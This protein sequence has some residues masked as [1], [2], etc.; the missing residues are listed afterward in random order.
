MSTQT[1]AALRAAVRRLPLAALLFA[2][3][4]QAQYKI[5]GPD[6]KVTYT[7][8]PPA[9]VPAER[10]VPMSRGAADE[11]SSNAALPLEL[12]QV[13]SRYP[14]TLY[15]AANCAPCDTGR[16]LLQQ[17]GIPYAERTASTTEDTQALERL[18]GG[19]EVPVLTIGGQVLR[20][21][22]SDSWN[23]YLDAAGYPRESK[24]P[25]GYRQPPATALVPPPTA[26]AR[27]Q[28]IQVLPAGPEMR[29]TPQTSP[30]GIRF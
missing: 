7:D 5:V 21:L 30:E 29:P 3:A 23:S 19:R 11:S 27:S 9:S 26:P 28:P 13:A 12:R 18:S 10:V 2:A 15:T 24:L 8:R 16:Q 6:G 17:R 22:Q 4:A 25:A 20:G 14:V 1:G